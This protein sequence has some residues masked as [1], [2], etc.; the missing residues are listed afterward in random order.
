VREELVNL[1]AE[2]VYREAL[3]QESIAPYGPG[4]LEETRFSPL[5][6][7]FTVPL[8]PEVELGDY[9]SYRRPFEQGEVSQEALAEALQAVQEQNAVLAPL[10]RAATEGDLVVVELVGRTSNGEVFVDQEEAHILLDPGADEPV[11]GLSQALI[12]MQRD[13]ERPFTLVLPASFPVEELQGTEAEF[14]AKAKGIYEQIIPELDDDLARTVG[15]YDTFE[16]L[17][18]D[19]RRRL[20]NREWATVES[21][22][23]DQVLQDI[24]DRAAVSWPPVML[25]EAMNDAIESREQQVERRDH[26]LLE[27]YL[28]IRGKT[29]EDLREELRPE[30]EESLKRSLVLQEIVQLEGLAVSDEDLD[31]RITEAS[32]QYGDR[33]DEVREALSTSDGRR[34]LRNRM[35]ANVAVQ[36][37]VSIAKGEVGQAPPPGD[38]PGETE[39]TEESEE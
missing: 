20:Q 21:E 24:V 8:A 34:D 18:G 37:L 19:I 33:A 25:E 9:R 4:T 7:T 11:P 35:L 17:R 1:L 38:E 10:D 2:D 28:R 13:E 14:S 32:E 23:A 30:V 22:Y 5:T 31:R 16:E 12:G 15:N 26:M 29:M 27:D 3:E 6:L 36:R 39:E